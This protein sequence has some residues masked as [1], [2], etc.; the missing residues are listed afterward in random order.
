MPLTRLAAALAAS[1]LLLATG[2]TQALAS[3]GG[4]GTAPPPPPPAGAAAVSLSPSTV[5]YAAQDV[6]TTSAPQTITITNTGTASLFFSGMRQAGLNPLDFAEIDDQCV[7][8]SIAAGASCTLTVVFKPTATGSRTATI[9][10]S[11]NAASSPQVITLTGTG[12]S[13]AGATPLSVDI[14]GMTC[15]AGVCSPAADSLVNDFFFAGFNAVGDT[16]PPFTWSLAGGALPPGVTLF[17]NG[18]IYGTATATGTYTFTLRVTDPNGKTA[19]QAF[20][21]KIL[22]VPAAGD[23]GCQHAPSSSNAALSGPA[24]AG[25]TPTGQAIGD[26]SKLTACGGFVTINVSVKNVNVPNGTV[27]WVVMRGGPPIGTLTINNGAATMK[28]YVL[29]SDL[30]KKGVAIY[31][32]Q[33]QLTSGATPLLSGSFI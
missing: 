13:A 28:P 14:G 4:G 24:I 33:P 25:K 8:L 20:A 27:L 11:D 29:N 15:T 10:V 9:S 26:Q 21:V 7:G 3:H 12:T 32:Q 22:P 2:A 19:T 23:P 18:T 6:G 1:A 17:P 31:S 16:A 5:A 30:R